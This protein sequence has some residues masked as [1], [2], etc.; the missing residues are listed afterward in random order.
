ML[1]PSSVWGPNSGQLDSCTQSGRIMNSFYRWW[2]GVNGVLLTGI[3]VLVGVL[4]PLLVGH[5]LVIVLLLGVSR[6]FDVVFQDAWRLL[7]V[8]EK[9]G[10]E[11]GFKDES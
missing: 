7:E 4:L 1:R 10:Q 9:V 11:G 5:G 6:Y 2:L 8:S 3:V